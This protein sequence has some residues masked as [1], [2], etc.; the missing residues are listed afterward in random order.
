MLLAGCP[1]GDD[2]PSST[3]GPDLTSTGTPDDDGGPNSNVSLN[4]DSSDGG[5]D[6]SSDGGPGSS[7]DGGPG[8]SSSDGGPGSSSSEGGESSSSSEGGASSSSSSDDGIVSASSSS[9]EGGETDP[10][11]TTVEPPTDGFGDCVNNPIEEAC[12]PEEDCFTAGAFG[13]C[14]LLNCVDASDCPD[15]PPGGDAP[16]VCFNFGVFACA[17]DCAGGQTCPDGM[18]CE[19]D[20]CAWPQEAGPDGDCC[21]PHPTTGCQNDTVEACVCAL[22]DFCC[23][24]EWDGICVDEAINECGADC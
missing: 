4:P 19:L 7:S 21:L 12:L 10:G 2:N 15:A 1:G 17:I 18:V 5:P 8:S 6:S 11:T 9:S 3:E 22:D 24:T 23:N 13:F 16:V 20:F 14:G